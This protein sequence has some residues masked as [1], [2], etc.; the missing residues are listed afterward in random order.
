MSATRKK[1]NEMSSVERRKMY[2]R[3]K[4]IQALHQ[5][6][7]IFI[8]TVV[9]VFFGVIGLNVFNAKAKA[10][11]NDKVLYKYYKN[12]EIQPNDTLWELAKEN[13]CAEKQTFKNYIQEVKQ[14]NHLTDEESIIAG[15]YIVLPYYSE[16]FIYKTGLN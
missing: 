9:I 4:H 12:V 7:C 10:L 11:Q 1:F 5:R 8:L 3:R 14:I 2:K 6:L 13:Y 15:N 16:T